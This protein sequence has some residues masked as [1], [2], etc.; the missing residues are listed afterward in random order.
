MTEDNDNQN[1]EE[2]VVVPP[3]PPKPPQIRLTKD[4]DSNVKHKKNE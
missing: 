1:T 2:A 3:P 4:S